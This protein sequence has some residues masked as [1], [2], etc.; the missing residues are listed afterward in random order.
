MASSTRFAR[1]EVSRCSLL[2]SEIIMSPFG[3]PI[4]LFNEATRIGSPSDPSKACSL[5]SGAIFVGAVAFS[6]TAASVNEGASVNQESTV[7]RREFANPSKSFTMSSN[8]LTRSTVDDELSLL[9]ASEVSD[10]ISMFGFSASSILDARK[11]DM[12]DR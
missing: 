4:S 2:S 5:L 9:L 1:E 7:L 10:G 6:T 12:G 11:S 8:L 3:I